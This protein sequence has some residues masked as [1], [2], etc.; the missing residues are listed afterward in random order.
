MPPYESISDYQERSN[1]KVRD[2]CSHL[3]P[4]VS[5]NASRKIYSAFLDRKVV[6]LTKTR[7]QGRGRSIYGF[8]FPKASRNSSIETPARLRR[9]LKV[10][11]AT[12]GWFGT[13]SVAMCPGL[14]SMMWEP[15]W[16]ATPSRVY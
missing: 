16:R 14:V 9:L 2:I 12:S 11:L 15:F 6:H 8:Y 5:E 1:L 3:L 13:D 10:P 4:E 7:K